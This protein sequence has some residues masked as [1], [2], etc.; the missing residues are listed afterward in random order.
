MTLLNDCFL[1]TARG[2]E[3]SRTPVWMMRQAGRYLPEYRKIRSQVSDFIQ[4]KT[5]SLPGLDLGP[6]RSD[7]YR[8]DLVRYL[9]LPERGPEPPR[10][11]PLPPLRLRHRPDEPSRRL[12][13]W[14]AAQRARRH[15]S[16]HV[17]ADDDAQRTQAARALLR[18]P[19]GAP[20]RSR[21]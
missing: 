12:R 16:D 9:L 6:R 18:E 5:E 14:R 1:R 2:E 7:I 19:R 13:R 11:P 10:D 4:L 15:A 21:G 3:L 8:T 20:I 17:S